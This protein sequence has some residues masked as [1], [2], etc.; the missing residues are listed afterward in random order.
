M[1]NL[2]NSIRQIPKATYV[3]LQPASPLPSSGRSIPKF[4]YVRQLD[5]Q[6]G[7]V[8]QVQSSLTVLNAT[9]AAGSGL[10]DA[11]FWSLLKQF[12]GSP[13]PAALPSPSVFADIPES[14]LTTFGN[15]LAAVRNQ[16]L[17]QTNAAP[18]TAQIA[19]AASSTTTT[20]SPSNGDLLDR[21]NKSLAA[22]NV[23]VANVTAQPIGML[24][25]E[26]LEMTPADVERGELLATIPLAP[27]ERTAVVQK[28]WSVIKQEFTSI[29]SDSLDNY[30]E[31][32]VTEN[33][34][35]AQSTD[36][37]NSHSNQFNVNAT[38]SGSYGGFVSASVSTGFTTQDQSSVSA[39]NSRKDAVAQTRKASSRVKQSHK[40]TI[41]TT[42]VTGTSDTTTR[43][44][45]N[46]SATDPIRIDYFSLMR[47]WYVALYR[48]GL[49]MTYD[50]AIP[51]PGGAMRDL[52]RQLAEL[53]TQASKTFSFSISYAQID[54]NNMAALE[55]IGEQYGAAIPQAPVGGI[56]YV[57]SQTA[58][59]PADKS[60][61][62][63]V[64]PLTINFSIADG[65]QVDHIEMS[66]NIGENHAGWQF[67]IL[68]YP[69]QFNEQ[70]PGPGQPVIPSTN[71]Y[72][73]NYADVPLGDF[74][75]GATGSL[76]ITLTFQYANPAIA[77]F[78]VFTVPTAAAIQ[79]WQGSVYTALY[80]AAQSAYYTQQ[81]A[82][83]AQ[84]AA[85]QQQI[86]SV[87]TL[88]LRREENDE[89]M[90]CV[91]QWLLGPS[92]DFMPADVVALYKSQGSDALD[93]GVGFT[94]NELKLS[95]AQWTT[96]FTYQEM[97]KFINEAIE[98]ENVV[99]YL[100]S[101]FWDI[102]T[103][104]AFIRQIQHPDPMRQAFLRAGSARVVLT[105]RPG[106]EQAWAAFVELGDFGKILPPGHPY[107][108][109]AQQ[110]QAYDS[111]NYPGIPAADP[112]GGGPI[113]DDTPQFGSTCE[114]N[115]APSATAPLTTPVVIPVDDASGFLVGATA[116]IDNWNA[117]IDPSTGIGVQEIQTI[118]AISTTAPQSITVQGLQ[119]SHTAPFPVVQGGAKGT[120]IAE[121]FEYT[122]TSGVD[123][124]VTTNQ[125]TTALGAP[126]A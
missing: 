121:W 29:V 10:A 85:L 6:P 78:K 69:T 7:E 35:L 71:F 84:I 39:K 97:I 124:A 91:L 38:V 43:M 34:E 42:T 9:T 120:L 105:V 89:I 33:T 54:P 4:G 62:I 12:E 53:Q 99:Y 108:T 126:P 90:K 25:L 59:T 98:W 114:S 88:T 51:E 50:I 41:S 32:G 82:I 115:I 92:F 8:D 86:T 119:Y 37:E 61:N 118:T 70:N 81:Q 60:S 15:A 48:F 122:P 72:E 110:I 56:T 17:T 76:A 28:E 52:Y 19:N 102:P 104:W 100:Y 58:N 21:Y 20:T 68:G 117:Q 101:Y 107:F 16:A 47:K 49:R 66:Y 22:N 79:A 1:A 31:T 95:A 106:F 46:P 55:K 18:R 14:Q 26:R 64:I 73:W 2:T 13:L 109:I 23:F 77:S 116:I 112:D 113:D 63:N 44:L 36:S 96:M 87:D 3:P 94:G 45:E 5:L 65:L 40:M 83:N 11:N 111:T 123:I 103:S 27:K 125:A 80:N 93:Y 57:P 75:A 67:D 24:N 74:M 30:S